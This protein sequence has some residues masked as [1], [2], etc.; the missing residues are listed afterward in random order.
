[1]S[2]NTSTTCAA[3]GC[4]EAPLGLDLCYEHLAH[5]LWLSEGIAPPFPID[6]ALDGAWW[7][8]SLEEVCTR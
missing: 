6:P 1:M 3:E 5:E 4:A 2:D 7:G 8:D